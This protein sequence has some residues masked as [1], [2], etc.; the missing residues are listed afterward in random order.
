MFVQHAPVP[1]C[2]KAPVQENGA[3]NRY[4]HLAL[5]YF[6]KPKVGCEYEFAFQPSF[7]NDRYRGIGKNGNN[8]FA[9]MLPIGLGL[10]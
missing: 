7:L 9:S 3:N 5:L 2:P 8:R 6:F 10:P 4:G 1:S